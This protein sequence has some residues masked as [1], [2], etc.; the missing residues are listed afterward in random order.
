MCAKLPRKACAA[1][2]CA[3]A[4]SRG[5]RVRPPHARAHRHPSPATRIAPG[6]DSGQ[7]PKP[8][9]GMLSPFLRPAPLTPPP[10]HRTAWW[11]RGVLPSPWTPS[12]WLGRSVAGGWGRG[13]ARGRGKAPEPGLGQ[14]GSQVHKAFGSTGA[15][16]GGPAGWIWGGDFVLREPAAD[17]V[18]VIRI[19]TS[20][21]TCTHS[22]WT[23]LST[24][25]SSP[26]T[27]SQRPPPAP[28][29]PWPPQRQPQPAPRPPSPHRPSPTARHHS[30]VQ[31]LSRKQ[32]P[33]AAGAAAIRTVAA[34]RVRHR[35]A[36]GGR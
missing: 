34:T 18:L 22:P 17:A 23:P 20:A 36:A 10:P 12:P 25:T 33:E 2:A 7:P 32:R 9:N 4:A 21:L 3:A 1:A 35:W 13:T 27:T 26:S 28:P 6:S 29:P 24:S 11:S 15:T 5:G 8:P 31:T 16:A 30:P 19:L 14:L